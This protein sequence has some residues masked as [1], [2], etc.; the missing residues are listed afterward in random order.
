MPAPIAT[1]AAASPTFASGP[2]GADV[3]SNPDAALEE[4][5]C[6]SSSVA[7]LAE[8]SESAS[9]ATLTADRL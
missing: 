9:A 3:V 6:P 8:I 2:W 1:P 5:C 7:G 4:G